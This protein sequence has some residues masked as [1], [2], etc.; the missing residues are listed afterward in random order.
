MAENGLFGKIWP[1]LGPLGP[2]GATFW[3]PKMPKQTPLNV[4]DNF[5]PYSTNV[6]PIWSSWRC[7]QPKKD[8]FEPK[9]AVFGRFWDPPVIFYGGT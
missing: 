6:Q 9:K 4:F 8:H 2:P 7:L 3:G 1:F 5:Q